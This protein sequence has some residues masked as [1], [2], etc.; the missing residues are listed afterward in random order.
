MDVAAYAPPIVPFTYPSEDHWPKV[1]T[2]N[3]QPMTMELVN[4]C[5]R[6]NILVPAKDLEH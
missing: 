3:N 4:T 1:V 6:M 5:N 2:A